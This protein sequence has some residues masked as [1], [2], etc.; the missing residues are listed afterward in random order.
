MKTP[1]IV[2]EWLAWFRA[3][4]PVFVWTPVALIV[5]LW[6]LLAVLA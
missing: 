3:Q 1:K 5:L 4:P 2:D 6:L